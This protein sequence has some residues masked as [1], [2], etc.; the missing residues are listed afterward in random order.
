MIFPLY[1]E[2]AGQFKQFST[3][4]KVVDS[5][6]MIEMRRTKENASLKKRKRGNEGKPQGGSFTRGS[7]P[8]TST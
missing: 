3:Y 6:R 2:M 5:V 4:A 8:P 7:K 1:N